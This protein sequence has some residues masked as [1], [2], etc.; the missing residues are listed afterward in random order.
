MFRTVL[1]K[2][3][4]KKKKIMEKNNA[5]RL[6]EETR[7]EDG[8]LVYR[9]QNEGQEPLKVFRNISRNFIQFHFCGKGDGTFLFN[10]GSYKMPGVCDDGR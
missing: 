9:F 1:N 6:C 3:L 10:N 5:E 4:R 8:I 7:L 2:R